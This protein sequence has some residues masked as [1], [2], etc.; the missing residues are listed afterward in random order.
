MSTSQF[1]LQ[2]RQQEQQRREQAEIQQQQQ[3]VKPLTT[4]SITKTEEERLREFRQRIEQHQQ[5]DQ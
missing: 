1:C 2:Q 3:P 4:P 5:Q